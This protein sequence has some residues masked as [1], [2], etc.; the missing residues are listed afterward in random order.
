[1]QLRDCFIAALGVVVFICIQQGISWVTIFDSVNEYILLFTFLTI[2]VILVYVKMSERPKLTYETYLRL[3]KVLD[4]QYLESEAAGNRV[5]EEHLF[6][7]VHQAFEIWFK[8]IL[9][10]LGGVITTFQ[11]P[12]FDDRKHLATITK[13]LGRI[14][15][16]L[17]L[18]VQHFEILETMPPAVFLNFRKYLKSGS[19]FESLQFRL[20]ENRFGL[21]QLAREAVKGQVYKDKLNSTQKMK[22][23]ESEEEP[24]LFTVVK[25]WL[26]NVF[27]TCTERDSQ[28]YLSSINTAV[29]K[30]AEDENTAETQKVDKDAFG[31]ILTKETYNSLSEKR[32]S[33]EAF[34]GALLISLYQDEPEFQMAYMT[35]KLIMDVECLISKWRHTHVLM[36]HRMLGRKMGTGGSSGYDYL[37]STNQDTYRVFIELFNLSAFLIPDEY[38]AE[39]KPYTIPKCGKISSPN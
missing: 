15:L 11:I 29:S 8:Q 32:L 5:D 24:S 30:W 10:D 12:D 36:V 19:G 38:K 1:M 25:N 18:V 6:I 14:A 3:D 9:E 31:K 37:K 22:A 28:N 39:R 21:Q 26:K 33:F 20:I 17:K 13:K 27:T 34:Y 7:I 4:S 35:L 2:A 23:V 16:I